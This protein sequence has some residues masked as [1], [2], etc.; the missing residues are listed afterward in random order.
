MPGIA[1]TA[2]GWPV[3][4]P[5]RP[6][7]VS[8]DG[9]VRHLILPSARSTAAMRPPHPAS[10]ER[11]RE[12]HVGVLVVDGKS[13]LDA[14]ENAAVAHLRLPQKRAGVGVQPATASRTSAPP[15]HTASRAIVASTGALAKFVVGTG[16]RRT[17]HAAAVPGRSKQPPFHASPGVACAVQ[18][19]LACVH[20]ERA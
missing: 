15:Q 16:R 6:P 11:V 1:L 2:A 4:Q 9:G 3:L 10:L 12:R 19:I 7:H 20:G 8:P 17:M 14:A 18:R 13:P 5:V